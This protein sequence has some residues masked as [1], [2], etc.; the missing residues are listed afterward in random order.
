MLC[1]LITVRFRTLNRGCMETRMAWYEAVPNGTAPS[2]RTAVIPYISIEGKDSHSVLFL[3]ATVRM[4]DECL[5][6]IL[7]QMVVVGIEV[8]V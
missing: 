2:E 5:A 7:W 4:T 8:T 6:R 3:Y 1:E